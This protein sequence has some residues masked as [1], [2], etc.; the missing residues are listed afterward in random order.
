MQPEKK[1]LPKSMPAILGNFLTAGVFL[2]SIA[3]AAAYLGSAMPWSILQNSES[4]KSPLAFDAPARYAA[5]ENAATKQSAH[6][7]TAA[8]VTPDG[9]VV[10]LDDWHYTGGGS[11]ASGHK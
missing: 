3:G 10:V 1:S 8:A 7:A 9:E 6:K 11:P 2:A 5:Y 4:F